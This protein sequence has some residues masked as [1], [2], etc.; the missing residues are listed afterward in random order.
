MPQEA[1]RRSVVHQ[2]PEV[3]GRKSVT[4]FDTAR[5][6]VLTRHG[7][8]PAR[9]ASGV[10]SK[11]K[12][13]QDRGVVCWPFN[14]SHNQALLCIFD[15]HGMQGERV[16]EWCM[17]QI[18]VRLEAAR[19]TLAANPPQALS[20]TVR[21]ARHTDPPGLLPLATP[22]APRASPARRRD[23]APLARPSPLLAPLLRLT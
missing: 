18:P 10:V 15:G 21:R 2:A 11:A 12:I 9:G 6:G 23:A 3:D 7:I 13:N 20:Q 8:A 19:A 1:R 16:S 4:T 17:N 22:R 14:G 5:V